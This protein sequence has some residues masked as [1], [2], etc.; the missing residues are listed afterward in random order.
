MNKDGDSF[1]HISG[2]FSFFSKAKKKAGIFT[3][4]QVRLMKAL[5]I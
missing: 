1:H 2:L 4:A 5:K 3:G